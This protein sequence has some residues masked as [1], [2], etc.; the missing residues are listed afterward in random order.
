LLPARGVAAP[1]IDG[2]RALTLALVLAAVALAHVVYLW[3]VAFL[4]LADA[5][6]ALLALCGCWLLLGTERKPVALAAAG[7]LLGL[8]A[9]IRAFYLYPLLGCLAAYFLLWA[10]DRSRRPVELLLLLALLPVAMQF[11]VVFERSG[12]LTYIDPE[13]QRKWADFHLRDSAAGYDT[14]LPVEAFRW[15]SHCSEDDAGFL[16][17]WERADAALGLCLLQRRLTFYFGSHATQTF[18]EA[19][20]L[21]LHQFVG[22]TTLQTNVRS[23]LVWINAAPS[24][25]GR[26]AGVRMEPV[27]EQG[28]LGVEFVIVPEQSTDY[29]FS[30]WAWSLQVEAI[31]LLFLRGGTC[32]G[33]GDGAD[34]GARRE[35]LAT[36]VIELGPEP[37]R[38]AVSAPLQAGV[39]QCLFIGA[40]DGRDIRWTGTERRS[41]LIWGGKLE[42]GLA[43]V[44]W[45][46]KADPRLGEARRHWLPGLLAAHAV[47]A[48]LVLAAGWRNRRRLGRAVLT[49]AGFAGLLLAQGLVIVPEQRF[50]IVFE[51]LL[52]VAAIA[53]IRHLVASRRPA[54]APQ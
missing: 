48:G 1:R 20:D 54:A 50:V 45:K 35:V 24:P 29:V 34:G 9:S 23:A 39:R 25:D 12:R 19:E 8:A 5:P 15:P 40:L 21:D 30:V 3:P 44:P 42:P 43:P 7:L 38:H 26:N 2:A 52:W 49:V 27:G 41:L 46:P 32:D 33:G 6:A 14:L 31:E 53:A 11:A 4:A 13:Q 36:R 28:D 10:V 37:V 47:A 16:D 18:L 22:V 51:V 17:A